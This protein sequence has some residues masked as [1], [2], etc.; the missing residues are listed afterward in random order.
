[1]LH[2]CIIANRSVLCRS[3]RKALDTWSRLF[4][5]GNG[6]GYGLAYNLQHPEKTETPESTW[7]LKL[8]LAKNK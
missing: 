3:V 4:L 2:C 1:M 7:F 8:K 5:R 6:N